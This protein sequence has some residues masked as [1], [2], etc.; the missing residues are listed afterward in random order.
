MSICK[1]VRYTV[2][3]D[4]CINWTTTMEGESSEEVIKTLT[5]CGWYIGDDNVI[6]PICNIKENAMK[7]KWK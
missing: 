4:K 3:C 2:K 1:H 6:C 5:N 7:L